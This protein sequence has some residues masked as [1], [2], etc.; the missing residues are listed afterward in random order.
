MRSL[1]KRAGVAFAISAAIAL[2]AM[3]VHA[4]PDKGKPVSIVVPY[5]FRKLD[6]PLAPMALT[7]IL[8]PLM[9][10]GLRLSLELSNGE[11]SVFFVRPISGTLMGLAAL[12]ILYAAFERGSKVRGSDGE[13]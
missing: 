6:I 7:L 1:T 10:Q 11:F 12:S 3:P 8:G 9:E 5:A 13:V 4:F 2:S